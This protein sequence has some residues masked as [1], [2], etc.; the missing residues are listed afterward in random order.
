MVVIE[1]MIVYVLKIKD[2]IIDEIF[3]YLLLFECE[4]L[5]KRLNKVILNLC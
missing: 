2:R 4:K 3:V 5:I 1:Y